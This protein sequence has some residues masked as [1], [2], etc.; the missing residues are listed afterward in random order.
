MNQ[1]LMMISLHKMNLNFIK[2]LKV[3]DPETLIGLILPKLLD[4]VRSDMEEASEIRNLLEDF[5]FLGTT[6]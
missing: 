2:H 3:K 6:H 1:I 4:Q 5:F